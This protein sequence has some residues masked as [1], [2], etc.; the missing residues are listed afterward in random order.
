MNSK[1]FRSILLVSLIVF[2]SSLLFIMGSLHSYFTSV[3]QNQLKIEAQLAAAGVSLL[4]EEYLKNFDEESFRLTWIAEDG[5]VL[6]DN[7]S[8]SGGMENHLE[9]EEIK[10]AFESGYGESKRYSDTLSERLL[11]SAT[12]LPDGSVLRVSNAQS[13]IWL[14]MLGF[15]HQIILVIG[16]ALV[17]SLILAFQLSKRITEPINRIDPNEP[18]QYIGKEEYKEIEPLLE[19]MDQLQK[20]AKK[21][22]AELENMSKIRQDF[23]ANV[24]HELKT[25]LQAISGCAELLEQGMVKEEDIPAF[26]GKIRMESQRMTNLV[27]DIIHL[28]ELD[29][30]GRDYRREIIDLKRVAENAVS[31]LRPIAEE[32]GIQLTLVGESAE[33]MGFPDVLYSIVFNLCDNA[34]KY[35]RSG[36][37]VEVR[38]ENGPSFASL[39]VKDTGIGI[40]EECRE[41][42]F[43]RFYRIDKSRSKEVGGTGLGLSIVKHGA[44]IHDATV[45]VESV[46]DCGTEFFLDFPKAFSG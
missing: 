42:I 25:P 24:S 4:G 21:N 30:G 31:S 44:I 41:R 29:S 11:Y 5:T 46:P 26:A 3:Q 16:I 35:N 8:P 9:R 28:T 32:C 22:Q 1:I 6:Y 40:P 19:R 45:Q 20:K 15:T 23:T 2:L 10:E 38:V 34:I 14:L 33:M 36:G 27:E 13:A 12:L 18:E 39:S 7:K 43:E 37:K 17:L